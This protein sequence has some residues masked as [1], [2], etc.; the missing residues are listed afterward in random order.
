M[1]H[2][3][4]TSEALKQHLTISEQVHVDP[5]EESRYQGI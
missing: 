1:S 3:K 5:F 4:G 2:R